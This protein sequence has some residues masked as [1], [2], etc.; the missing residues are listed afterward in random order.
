MID[1]NKFNPFEAL[2]LAADWVGDTA[3]SVNEL[4]PEGVLG[5]SDNPEAKLMESLGHFLA[6]VNLC[7]SL[8]IIDGQELDAKATDYENKYAPL[9]EALKN[10][11]E[12][13]DVE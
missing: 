4:G 11:D 3:D 9:Y 10:A 12:G 8:N 2:M 5:L 1:L 13:T 6:L 7:V